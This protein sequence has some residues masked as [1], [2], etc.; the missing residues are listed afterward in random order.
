MSWQAFEER[1]YLDYEHFVLATH[2]HILN[3][4]IFLVFV[5]Y[6]VYYFNESI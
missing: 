6:S 1:F 5:L 2:R 3:N 4:V